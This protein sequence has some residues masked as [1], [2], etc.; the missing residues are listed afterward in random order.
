MKAIWDKMSEKL[1]RM[2]FF[3]L[4]TAGTVKHCKSLVGDC[5][6]LDMCVYQGVS[7]CLT[8]RRCSSLTFTSQVHFKSSTEQKLTF[9]L[10][11]LSLCTET[12]ATSSRHRT[13]AHL[14][15][16]KSVS[17]H[18]MPPMLQL[19]C[20][21][22]AKVMQKHLLCFNHSIVRWRKLE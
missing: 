12:L 16:Q 22:M 9:S 14:F 7:A 10:L 18:N 17:S 21:A 2:R 4:N 13:G 8:K 20:Q 6:F 15:L 1:K 19:K 11:N 3:L 5:F